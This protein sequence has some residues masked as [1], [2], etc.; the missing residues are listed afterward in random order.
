M[1]V[2]MD[3]EWV[4][5]GKAISRTLSLIEELAAAEGRQRE[6]S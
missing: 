6:G 1:Y 5:K 4:T 2:I 3:I